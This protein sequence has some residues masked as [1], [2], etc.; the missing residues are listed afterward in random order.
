ME[1]IRGQTA[2]G[3]GGFAFVDLRLLG[4]AVLDFE[5]V[6]EGVE[7][8]LSLREELEMERKRRNAAWIEHSRFRACNVCR[9]RML[10][11]T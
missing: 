7:A 2:F 10:E 8:A 4:R 9:V 11:N 6:A 1:H 5:L 3:V